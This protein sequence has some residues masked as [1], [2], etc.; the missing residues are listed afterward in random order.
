MHFGSQRWKILRFE[1]FARRRITPAMAA[2]IADHVWSIEE[3]VAL[4]DTRAKRRREDNMRTSTLKESLLLT[5]LSI[6]VAVLLVVAFV[7]FH[8]SPYQPWLTETWPLPGG[9]G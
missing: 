8:F 2:G 7:S 3:I 5:A 4:L 9:G 6:L 1:Q